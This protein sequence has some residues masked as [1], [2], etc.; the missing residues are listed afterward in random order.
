MGI[1]THLPHLAHIL[2]PIFHGIEY[3][4]ADRN[5]LAVNGF[6]LRSTPDFRLT[7]ILDIH[8]PWH[9]KDFCTIQCFDGDCSNI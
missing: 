5:I 9:T 4:F 7:I 8:F 6:L 3:D 1:S 2:G